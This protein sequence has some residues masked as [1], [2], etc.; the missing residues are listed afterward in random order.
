MLYVTINRWDAQ[1]AV[2][3][4]SVTVDFDYRIV[5]HDG[6]ELWKAHQ[7]MV[8]QP[9]NANAGNP[10]ATLIAAAITAAMARAKPNYLPLARQA[11]YAAIVTGP[12]AIPDGPYKKA[13]A[14]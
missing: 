2:L 6:T 12:S 9:Q 1:Y 3:S 5:Y 11:N 14:H 4:T 13:A 8:Y 7:A 10:L